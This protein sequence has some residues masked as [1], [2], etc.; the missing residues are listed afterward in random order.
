MRPRL[1]FIQLHPSSFVEDDKALLAVEYDL[2]VFSFTGGESASAA[3]R[4]VGLLLSFLRQF[5]WLRRELARPSMVYGWFADYH[6]ILPVLMARRRGIPAVVVLGGFDANHLPELGYGA[7]HSCWRAPLV[8]RVVRKASLL[9]AG[10]RSLLEGESSFATWPDVRRNGICVHVPGLST[11]AELIPNGFDPDA[12]PAGPD[13]RAR[14]VVTVAGI[15]SNRT[16]LVKGLDLF[17]ETA[18]R[19]PDTR[20]IAAGIPDGRAEAMRQQW[21]VPDNVQLLP[22]RP[23]A[24]L[25]ELYATASVYLQLSRTEGG[26]P[27]VLAE[28]M[29][30]GCIPVASAVGGMVETVGDAGFLVGKPDPDEIASTVR[31]AF[32][33]ADHPEEGPQARERARGRILDRFTLEKRRVRLREILGGLMERSC[34]GEEGPRS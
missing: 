26:L 21:R 12:W 34:N 23:R 4:A 2:R 8:R 17:F 6:M 25:A 27:M 16:A 19:M 22:P 20:F 29:L 30:C 10:T 18:R 32:D 31:R 28:S 24:E 1:L 14:T 15:I 33:L 5:R 3:G 9:L 7:L 11:P 13:A